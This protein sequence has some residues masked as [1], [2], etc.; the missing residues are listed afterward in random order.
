MPLAPKKTCHAENR[1]AAECALHF[2]HTPSLC[3]SYLNHLA[4]GSGKSAEN[5]DVFS[6]STTKGLPP[7]INREIAEFKNLSEKPFGKTFSCTQNC[8]RPF[9]PDQCRESQATQGKNRFIHPWLPAANEPHH[10]ALI[11]YHCNQPVRP[12]QA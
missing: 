3:Y 7:Y 1:I 5:A 2:Q 12:R 6:K 9:A 10:K 8:N 4:R 11:K